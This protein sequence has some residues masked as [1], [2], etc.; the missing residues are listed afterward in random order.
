[1]NLSLFAEQSYLHYS[2]CHLVPV[3]LPCLGIFEL[4]DLAVVGVVE[5][6]GQVVV[7]RASGTNDRR[8]DSASD[9]QLP[10]VAEGISASL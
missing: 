1:M 6:A 8:V 2:G 5:A 4:A 9:L 10:F 7:V 3:R